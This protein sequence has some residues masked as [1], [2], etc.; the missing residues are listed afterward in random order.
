[1]ISKIDDFREKKD[2]E[3][4]FDEEEDTQEGQ[5]LSFNIGKELYGIEIRYVT[6][7]VGKQ[8]ITEIPEMPDFVKGVINL[9]GSVIPVIDVRL[10]FSMQE[11]EYDDRTC[12]VVV[13]INESPIGLVVDTVSEVISIAPELISPAPAV[14]S[15]KSNR[16]I[17]GIGRMEKRVIILLSVDKMLAD[18]ADDLQVISKNLNDGNEIKTS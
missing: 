2:I 14:S 10:R 3:D 1:M 5:Y 13:K 11:R 8:S 9:R 15:A 12:V 17:Q 6:E 7:I 18:H 4:E 16:Y